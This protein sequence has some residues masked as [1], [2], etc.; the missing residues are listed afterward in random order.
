[1][2]LVHRLSLVT[3]DCVWQAESILVGLLAERANFPI[4]ENGTFAYRGRNRFS[5]WRFRM[6]PQYNPIKEI[7]R[8]FGRMSQQLEAVSE[9]MDSGE[10]ADTWTGLFEPMAIDVV[11]HDEQFVV[12]ADL[13]GFETDDLDI[14]VTNNRL[15]IEADREELTE[16]ETGRRLRHERRYSSLERSVRLPEDVDAEGVE[17][18]MENG[19]LHVTLPKQHVEEAHHIEI[20]GE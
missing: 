15:H 17:A 9:E 4:D 14:R 16:E 20:T 1:M 13:P 10:Q 8:F 19:V 11:E 6:T 7:E 2:S 12:T 18:T 3:I 5:M